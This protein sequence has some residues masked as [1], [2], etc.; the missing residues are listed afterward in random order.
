MNKKKKIIIIT[1]SILL[2][3]I[4]IILGIFIYLDNKVV[5][6]NEKFTLKEELDADVYSK[7]KV[8]DYIKNMEGEIIDNKRIDTESLGKKEITFYYYNKNKKKRIGQFNIEVKDRE[9]PL[10]W[11]MSDYYV[12]VGSD[13]D[14]IEDIMCVDNYDN[15]PICKIEG[16][17]DIGTVG[18]YPLKYTAIDKSKN[19][20]EV[21]FTLHVIKPS[22]K[23]ATPTDNKEEEKTLFKDIISKYKDEYNEVGI[24]I[25]KWQGEVDFKKV[26]DSGAS[27]VMIRIG[28]QAGVGGEYILDPYFDK[29]IKKAKEEKLKVGVYFYSYADSLKEAR[30]EADWVIEKLG[31]NKIDLPIVFD[32]EC[33]K[34]LNQMELSLFGLNKIAET[35]LKEVEKKGYSA[36]LYG[37]KNY[38]NAIWKYNSHDVWLAHY[39][40]E[41]DY[42][43]NYVMWQLCQDGIIDGID[44]S[45]DIDILYTT[46][47][48][49]NTFKEKE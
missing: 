37:S 11:L 33:Y 13:A 7:K 47:K 25:S 16:D 28:T 35:F 19:K 39:T 8:S 41:T 10:I 2:L 30:K 3:S 29:N 44:G 23:K 9:A 26:K 34:N 43:S 38:L 42:E 1:F 15:K 14:L 36:M 27:F 45:V 48:K 5:V 4:L 31:K 18:D 22:P 12:R 46:Q 49:N 24:D 40:E 32:W 17:Y 20:S 6:D 21:N